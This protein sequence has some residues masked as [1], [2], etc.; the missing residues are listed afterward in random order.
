MEAQASKEK[1]WTGYSHSHQPQTSF[2]DS[3]FLDLKSSPNIDF[4]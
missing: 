2:F 1:T 4:F 3:A